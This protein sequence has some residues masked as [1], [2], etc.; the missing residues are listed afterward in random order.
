MVLWLAA[1]GI[2]GASTRFVTSF[3]ALWKETIPQI[4]PSLLVMLIL[5]DL[6]DRMSCEIPCGV[7]RI[8]DLTA[9]S[10]VALR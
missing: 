6:L 10:D 2:L 9:W 7:E 1:R 8:L 4:K 3:A 5:K